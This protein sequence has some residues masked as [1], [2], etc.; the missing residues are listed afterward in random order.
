MNTNWERDM[1]I[2]LQ[3]RNRAVALILDGALQPGDP[4]PSVRNTA[5]ELQVN[6]LIVSRAYRQLVSEE[7][8]E[9]RQGTGVFVSETARD[10]LL[11]VERSRF[12]R[13]KWPAIT[14][15]MERLGIQPPALQP[16]DCLH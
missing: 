5:A 11:E 1:P 6:P 9:E 8:V 12:F 10:R 13:D 15:C 4:L 7:L 14:A 3:L 16:A 2:D